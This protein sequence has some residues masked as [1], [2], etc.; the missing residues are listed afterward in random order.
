MMSP[1]KSLQLML[2]VSEITLFLTG[3]L[4]SKL[5]GFS[6]LLTYIPMLVFFFV[7]LSAIV[8]YCQ[9]HKIVDDALMGD[10]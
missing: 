9:K 5:F 3:L 6:M 7:F 1:L 4:F 10:D 8:S 2:V